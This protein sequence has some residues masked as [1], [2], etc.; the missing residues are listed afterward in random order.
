LAPSLPL[1]GVPSSESIVR[2]IRVWSAA[3]DPASAGEIFF[4][5]FSTAFR[6]PLPE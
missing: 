3:S 4:V 1:F 5:M 2:S 6:V